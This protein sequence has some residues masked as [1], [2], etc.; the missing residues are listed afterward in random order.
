M[1]QKIFTNNSI[2]SK[3]N[4]LLQMGISRYINELIIHMAS[5]EIDG[6]LNDETGLLTAAF[7][8]NRTS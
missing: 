4:S 8:Q 2:C 1:R 6:Q 7:R 5:L 3:Y